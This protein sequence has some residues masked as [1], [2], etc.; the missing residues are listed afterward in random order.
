MK[1]L[2]VEGN[3][4]KAEGFMC[5]MWWFC[6]CSITKVSWKHTSVV[7]GHVTSLLTN[8][9]DALRLDATVFYLKCKNIA[10]ILSNTATACVCVSTLESFQNSIDHH[11]DPRDLYL[12][13]PE[14]PQPQSCLP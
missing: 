11:R 4:S 7:G 6:R 5:S 1:R 2:K 12:S 8:E 13:F 10:F 9:N 14:S 3:L